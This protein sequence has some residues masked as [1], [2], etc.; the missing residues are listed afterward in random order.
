MIPESGFLK[1]LDTFLGAAYEHSEALENLKLYQKLLLSQQDPATSMHLSVSLKKDWYNKHLDKFDLEVRGIVQQAM[2]K[3]MGALMVPAEELDQEIAWTL[4]HQPAVL[5][6]LFKDLLFLS[7]RNAQWTE[8]IAQYLTKGLETCLEIFNEIENNLKTEFNNK[9]KNQQTKI[10]AL[11]KLLKSVKEAPA[12]IKMAPKSS[13]ADKELEKLKVKL[14]SLENQNS[15]LVAREKALETKLKE[16]VSSAKEKDLAPKETGKKKK[17]KTTSLESNSK[18]KNSQLLM[19]FDAPEP[20]LQSKKLSGVKKI[21]KITK[22]ERM[23]RFETSIMDYCTI[24]STAVLSEPDLP[25]GLFDSGV[26]EGFLELVIE[27]IPKINSKKELLVDRSGFMKGILELAIKVIDG[28]K[29]VRFSEEQMLVCVPDV[30]PLNFNPKT[31]FWIKVLDPKSSILEGDKDPNKPAS[32]FV[33]QEQVTRQLQS[34]LTNFVN[35]L[36]MK[37]SE[38]S[39]KAANLRNKDDSLQPSSTPIK[40]LEI[41]QSLRKL[42]EIINQRSLLTKTLLLCY[43]F[44]ERVAFISGE[45]LTYYREE[46]EELLSERHWRDLPALGR[47]ITHWYTRMAG[48]CP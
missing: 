11:E 27:I 9:I 34:Y 18:S 15:Y 20:G 31:S 24:L 42:L 44:I 40:A 36:R 38:L 41:K 17:E 16:G 1:S 10:T 22:Q 4:K 13:K 5:C 14:I 25:T 29:R 21:K 48:M 43:I 47:E 8:V 12:A 45:Q 3:K 23:D 37:L 46:A 30:L 39:E 35:Y 26:F 7:M 6:G 2:K 19:V 32:K 33:V 28:K